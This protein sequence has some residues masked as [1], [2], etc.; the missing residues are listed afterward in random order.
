MGIQDNINEVMV[1]YN[2]DE[3]AFD[4]FLKSVVKGYI[5]ADTISADEYY[6]DKEDEEENIGGFGIDIA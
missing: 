6:E 5:S 3:K 4:D 2:G 1:E